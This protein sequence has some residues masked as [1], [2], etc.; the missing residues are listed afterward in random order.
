MRT[1]H[2]E[3]LKY[4][5]NIL[6]TIAT[7]V[8]LCGRKKHGRKKISGLNSL[9]HCIIIVSFLNIFV[10]F[11]IMFLKN[12]KRGSPPSFDH[13]L[14]GVTGR[15]FMI[16]IVFSVAGLG[17]IG[18]MLITSMIDRTVAVCIC[19]AICATIAWFALQYGKKLSE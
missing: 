2:G 5:R 7:P 17:M 3:R 13:D 18:S 11:S 19:I 14:E 4:T 1:F 8:L 9:R 16:S 6:T 15:Q 12:L 10:M